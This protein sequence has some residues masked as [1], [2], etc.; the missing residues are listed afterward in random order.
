VASST[1]DSSTGERRTAGAGTG[2][3]P[4]LRAGTDQQP[5]VSSTTGEQSPARIGTGERPLVGSASGQHPQV[6][7]GTGERKL[8][9]GG[10]GEHPQV[11]ANADEQPSIWDGT[12]EQ[13]SMRAGSGSTPAQPSAGSG[14]DG[15]QLPMTGTGD[16]A[17]THFGTGERLQ[18]RSLRPSGNPADDGSRAPQAG[19]PAG[20]S[21]GAA[22]TSA[23][24]SAGGDTEAIQAVPPAPA[25]TNA[26][27]SVA[28]THG[29]SG[30][31]HP[32]ATRGD[33]TAA[34]PDSEPPA[35]G[36]SLATVDLATRMEPAAT[37]D[38]EPGPDT[39]AV[40]ET[41]PTVG[42]SSRLGPDT[43]EP[44]LPG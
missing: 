31:A 3:Q 24:A 35:D 13:P 36:E 11:R 25:V 43:G 16:Q 19:T 38:D 44:D 39:T 34:G 7:S 12:G 30:P 2:E 33:E 23:E 4:P 10:S 29:P 8:A 9:G 26:R 1:G 5:P 41:R 22:P 14:V 20:A 40:L 27:S 28:A 37:S 21:A 42:P 15:R 18:V 32:V 17:Q 6:G